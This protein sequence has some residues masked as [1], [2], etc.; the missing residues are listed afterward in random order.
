MTKASHSLFDIKKAE[1]K[2][3]VE[4]YRPRMVH[5]KLGFGK[6]RSFPGNERRI[7]VDLKTNMW[8]PVSGN[9]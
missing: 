6:G 4:R 7:L 2:E 3:F 8:L 1:S 5:K 9:P